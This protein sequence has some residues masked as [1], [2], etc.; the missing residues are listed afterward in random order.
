[1]CTI[2]GSIW[3]PNGELAGDGG[4]SLDLSA[5]PRT[6]ND[7]PQLGGQIYQTQVTIPAGESYTNFAIPVA[8]PPEGCGYVISYGI[9]DPAPSQYKNDA[10]YCG[11]FLGPTSQLS[12]AY[13]LKVDGGNYWGIGM[14]ITRYRTISGNLTLPQ[15]EYAPAGG[16]P[17]TVYYV[18]GEG[19]GARTPEQLIQSAVAS[20]AC[21][22][23]EG[24][25]SAPFT[26]NYVLPNQRY[27]GWPQDIGNLDVQGYRLMYRLEDSVAGY[28]TYGFFNPVGT[29]ADYAAAEKID[30]TDHDQNNLSFTL[31]PEEANPI[32]IAGSVSL[33]GISY[34]GGILVR[35]V[36]ASGN[37]IASCTTDSTAVPLPRPMTDVQSCT[38]NFLDISPS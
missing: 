28:Q 3:L 27:I 14:E 11:H 6:L 33:Q 16:L 24:Q 30:V 26:F 21:V 34:A 19:G 37:E 17:L 7:P 36:N 4:I 23:P 32:E 25:S 22:I 35:L 29:V 1:L 9:N 8:L 15:G 13:V 2:N 12:M 5:I 31:L 38:K 10:F 18:T 20:V